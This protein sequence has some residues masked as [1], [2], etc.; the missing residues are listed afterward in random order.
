M[1]MDDGFVIIYVCICIMNT[2][3]LLF[4]DILFL[5]E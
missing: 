5:F 3:T 2:L 4:N 1:D